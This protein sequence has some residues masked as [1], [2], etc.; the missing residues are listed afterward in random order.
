MLFDPKWERNSLLG[1]ISWLETQDPNTEYVFTHSCD[2]LITRYCV[3]M[4]IEKENRSEELAM[5]YAGR[6]LGKVAIGTVTQQTQGLAQ[7]YGSALERARV[8]LIVKER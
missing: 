2:C 1:L 4:G 6:D 8:A 5:I 7:T 3:A